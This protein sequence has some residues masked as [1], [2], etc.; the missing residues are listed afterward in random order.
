M[1]KLLRVLLVSEPGGDLA[2]ITGLLEGNGFDV[3]SRNVWSAE[4][5]TSALISDPWD[6]AVCFE[7]PSSF[8]ALEAHVVIRETGAGIPLLVAASRAGEI[9]VERSVVPSAGGFTL[10]NG[11]RSLPATLEKIVAAAAKSGA[12]PEDDRQTLREIAQ[13]TLVGSAIGEYLTKVHG[14]LGRVLAAENCSVLLRDPLTGRADFAYWIDSLE[15]PGPKCPT[16]DFAETVLRTG[17][18]L[19]INKESRTSLNGSAAWMRSAKPW[20]SWIGVPLKSAARTTGVLALHAHDERVSF[21]EHDLA[22]LSLAA[23]QISIAIARGRSEMALLESEKRY[24]MLFDHAPDGIIM[25]DPAGRILD[26]NTSL[27]QFLGYSRGELLSMA[28]AEMVAPEEVGKIA[29]ALGE[30]A[31]SPEHHREWKFRRKDG[32][33]AFA[34][35]GAT[36]MPDGN[37]LAIIRDISERKE[38]E[39][40][41]SELH[42]EIAGQSE[43]L[44]NIISHIPGIVWETTIQ[45]DGKEMMSFVSEHITEMLGYTVDEWLSIFNSH[46]RP[47][48]SYNAANM[49]A[50]AGPERNRLRQTRLTAKDGRE[51]WV[52]ERSEWITNSSGERAGTR[53]VMIDITERKR[54][55]VALIESEKR[56]RDMV[57]NAIDIIYSHDLEGNYLAANAAA[58]RITGYTHTEIMTMNVGQVVAP[59]FL[60]RS[61]KMIAEKLE[62]GSDTAYEIE[63]LAKGGRRVALEVS[64]RLEFLDGKP[65]AVH[66]I[67]RDITERKLLAEELRQ[68]QKLEAIG[69]LAG[70]ISHDFNNLLTAIQGYSEITLARM[71]ADDPLRANIEQIKE[72]GERASALTHQLLAFSRKQVLK[73]IVHNLNSV[74]RDLDKMLRRIVRENIEFE[75]D[76]D[77]RLSNIEADP[78]QLEQVIVNLAVNA[79]DAMPTGGKLRIKTENIAGPPRRVKMTV[80]DSGEGIDQQVLERI[81][82]PFFTTKE[83]GKGSGLGLSTVHG[84]VKQSGGDISVASAKG[85]GATFEIILPAV[86]SA[87]AVC[88]KNCRPAVDLCGS[89]TVLLVEDDDAVRRLVRD[90]LLQR[91]YDVLEAASGD[92]ALEI[93]DRHAGPIDLLLTDLVMPRM[94]GIELTSRVVHVHPEAKPLVMTGYAGALPM[95]DPSLGFPA[96]YIEKPFTPDLLAQKVRE[97][98]GEGP[99]PRPQQPAVSTGVLNLP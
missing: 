31:V 30:I 28:A 91:G 66:G 59:E 12:R 46:P 17:R 62:A 29:L 25:A 47:G 9:V 53:G 44:N 79:Q 80:S 39:R 72:T 3:R 90:I 57:E 81:F 89:E 61:R 35:V 27:C 71:D 8:G 15:R 74:I 7:E 68:S 51:V 52:E 82:E 98:L 20:S 2:K 37:V 21:D 41:R 16:R 32:S 50:G 69:L 78:G 63:V 85:Q 18:P 38:A 48:A 36:R 42:T 88:A 45:P 43:R 96:P 83:S 11:I 49:R 60:E 5:L 22:F 73:P 14:M 65:V 34:D 6:C 13:T 93:C 33:I 55:E 19:L 87:D 10:S 70:G 99:A 23:D 58:E 64:T 97:V 77:E 40:E 56:Y 24:R 1:R 92:A 75:I 67:A 94:S 86:D 4:G 54:S 26:I 95:D 76:L 84:I